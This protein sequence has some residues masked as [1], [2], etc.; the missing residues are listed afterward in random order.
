MGKPMNIIDAILN[1]A[2]VHP[3][4]LSFILGLLGSIG[5]VVSFT[6]SLLLFAALVSS[7]INPIFA[8]LS[9][10]LGAALGEFSA[11]LLGYL[12]K[13]VVDLSGKTVNMP[14]N[15]K[16]FLT[17]L[18]GVLD[19]Y[20]DVTVFVFTLTPLPDDVLFAYLGTKKY[21]VIKIILPAFIGKTSLH[22]FVAYSAGILLFRTIL[23]P[24][25]IGF[26]GFIG[27]I[28]I[29][30]AGII[31]YYAISKI[32]LSSTSLKWVKRLKKYKGYIKAIIVLII[33]LI[34]KLLSRESEE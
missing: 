4:L 15:L 9:A 3:Y 30:I 28:I 33:A 26:E 23:T 13:T 31:F 32:D 12:G 16:N 22:L 2:S 27:Y 24:V 10:G 18:D 1:I 21:P 19:E 17:W 14:E 34:L 7:G 20:A 5:V 8:S 6:P 29:G 11:Y 25:L